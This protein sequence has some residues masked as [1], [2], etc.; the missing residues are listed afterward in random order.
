[1]SQLKTPLKNVPTRFSC[2]FRREENHEGVCAGDLQLDP[3]LLAHGLVGMDLEA[4]LVAI[5]AQR[6]V[7]ILNGNADELE[8][9]DHVVLLEAG[10]LGEAAR[11]VQRNRLAG[12]PV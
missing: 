11:D 7:L 12:R 1:L 2:P 9:T 3:S 10:N 8:L 6:P 4:E 5:E